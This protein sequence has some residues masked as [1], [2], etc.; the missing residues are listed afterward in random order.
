MLTLQEGK[1]ASINVSI[2]KSCMLDS[3][4]SEGYSDQT[5][6]LF[7]FSGWESQQI[8]FK[9]SN[10]PVFTTINIISIISYLWSGL[11]SSSIQNLSNASPSELNTDLCICVNLY[12]RSRQGRTMKCVPLSDR[13]VS[14]LMVSFQAKDKVG[15]SKDLQKAFLCK[16]SRQRKCCI[17]HTLSTFCACL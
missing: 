11:T 5:F 13:P 10:V 2:S 12:M 14:T 3:G 1:T 4:M 17:L 9:Q 7:R 8:S 16:N 6:G 15:L